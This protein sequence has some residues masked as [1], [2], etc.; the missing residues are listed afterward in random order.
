MFEFLI[1]FVCHHVLLKNLFQ[2]GGATVGALGV[3]DR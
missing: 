1:P 3:D 2:S